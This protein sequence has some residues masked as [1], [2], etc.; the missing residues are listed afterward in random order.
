MRHPSDATR[1][2]VLSTGGATGGLVA[3]WLAGCA[4]GGGSSTAGAPSAQPAT[5]RYLHV[6][7]GQ[8]VWQEQWG[9]L[10]ANFQAAYPALR[11]EVDSVAFGAPAIQKAIAAAAGGDYYDVLYG[12]STFIPS[13]LGADLLQPLD[14]FLT[15]DREVSAADID[16]PTTERYK[17]KLYGIAVRTFGKE[18]WYNADLFAQAGLPTPRQL[19]REGKWT[20]DALLDTARRLT[21]TDGG[22]TTTYGFSFAFTDTGSYHQLVWAW[23]GDWYDRGVT[24]PTLDA[25][26]FLQAT[27]FG[28]DLVAKHRVAGGGDFARGTVAMLVTSSCYARTVDEQIMRQSPFKVEIAMMPKGPAGRTTAV[29]N[30]PKY[31]AKGARAPE[32]AWLFYKYLLSK[33][34]LPQFARLG[35]GRYVANK[36]LKPIAPQ[37]N[38]DLAV[39]EASAAIRRA[40]T[41]LLKQADLDKDWAQAWKE[42]TEGTR[43][44]RE[45]LLQVQDRAALLLKDG[46]CLC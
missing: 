38:E 5:V 1:R 2:V 32:G 43:G 44:V 16:P 28:V 26:A 46:G 23:G 3:G 42:A 20:W 33:D 22:A 7:T 9:Q 41:V 21:R 27:Q 19:E 25:P 13:W 36:K 29:A 10:F 35:A 4:P 37:P 17:G 40:P 8:Q 45:A 14:G 12:H 15:G 31:I 39:Y 34:A 18:V 30:N 11:L 6:D 24:R